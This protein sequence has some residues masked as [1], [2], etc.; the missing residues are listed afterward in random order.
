MLPQNYLADV[1]G[2]RN[3][4]AVQMMIAFRILASF[5]N[6]APSHAELMERFGMSRATA[7][8]WRASL[9]EARGE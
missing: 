3:T 4:I 2:P 6:R 1:S 9:I 8:R 7:F 5:P